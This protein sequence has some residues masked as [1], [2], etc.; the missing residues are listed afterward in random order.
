M[1]AAVSSKARR[2]FR[3]FRVC[4]GFCLLRLHPGQFCK[5]V[6]SNDI[7]FSSPLELCPF[8][9]IEFFSEAVNQYCSSLERAGKHVFYLTKQQDWNA[10][11]R[12]FFVPRISHFLRSPFR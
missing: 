10:A 4:I 9:F 6:A 3:I 5:L 7:G 11:S 8:F 2:T 12:I 1:G